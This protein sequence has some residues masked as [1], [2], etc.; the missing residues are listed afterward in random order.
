MGRAL[1]RLPLIALRERRQEP[2]RPRVPEPMVMDDP[3]SVDQ[4]HDGGAAV[5]GMQAV[6][7]LSARALDTLVPEGGRLL[8][9]GVG[10]GRALGRFLAMRPDV[11]AAGV[12][13]APN[14]LVTARRFLD[15]TGVGARVSLVEGDLTALPDEIK[16]QHWDAVSCVWSLHHLPRRDTL[17]AALRQI[18]EIRDEQG[19]A[20]W[21][22]DFHRLR[23]SD[24]WRSLTA[25]LQPD[26]PPLL[27][28]DALASEAAAFAHDELRAELGGAGLGGLEP[29]LARPI[30]W[31]QAFWCHGRAQ[32]ARRPALVQSE[33]L[34]GRA[35]LD[36][37]LLVRGFSRLPA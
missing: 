10:S 30:P 3:G 22:L 14:M 4:F 25:V 36:A 8:D 32:A 27:R 33:P 5:G 1:W 24:T 2:G 16:R 37:M 31:L 6:Y 20:I 35:R 17:Q 26:M 13:L 34:R 15:E 7:D 29:G 21:L 28:A 12:D 9:L 23:N 11:S 18:A 19:S